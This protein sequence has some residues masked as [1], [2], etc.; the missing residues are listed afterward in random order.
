MADGRR[1]LLGKTRIEALSDG[2]FA[3]VVTLLV[4]E[5]RVPEPND[6]TSASALAAALAGMAPKF[7]SL[8]ISFLTV[9]VIWLNHHRLFTVLASADVSFFWLNANL[10]LW[11]SV[12]PFP[13]A[14][15]GDFPAN[16]MGLSLYGVVMAL[17]A[18]AFVFMRLHMQ[19]STGLHSDVDAQA[20]RSGTVWATLLGPVAYLTGALVSWFWAPLAF[21]IYLGIPAYFVLPHAA[22]ARTD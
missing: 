11:V 1:E 15:I 7:L 10:L 4:L 21:A 13:T 9:C 19:R 12:I 2:V 5:L 16:A 6:A 20:F 17:M 8:V 18:A 22:R 3:I 14:L